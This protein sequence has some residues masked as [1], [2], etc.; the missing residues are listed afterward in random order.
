MQLKS[1]DEFLVSFCF[2]L[3][4]KWKLTLLQHGISRASHTV[5]EIIKKEMNFKFNKTFVDSFILFH[6]ILKYATPTHV[7]T[8]SDS[9]SLF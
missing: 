8:Q 4:T 5:L 2:L 9:F 1:P 6:F 7:N 3:T